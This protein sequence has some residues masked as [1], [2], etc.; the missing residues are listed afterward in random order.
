MHATAL[1]ELVEWW[2]DLSRQEINSRAVLL[3]VPPRWGRTHLLNQFTSVV[4]DDE[5]VS[6]VIRVPGASLPDGLG[7]QALELRRLFSEARVQ[8]RVAELLGVDRLGSA[9]Q[10]GLGVAGL[11][12]SPLATLVGL[13]LASV[14]VGA[15]SKVWDD[16][17]AGQEGMVAKLARAVATVSVSVP[18]VVIMDDADQLQP[19]LTVVLVENLIGRFDGRVLVV[20]AADPS[21]DLISALTSRAKYGLT[22]GRVRI[23]DAD[24]EMDYQA[25]ADLA[26]ELSPDLPA[27]AT[28]RIGQRTRTFAEV[29]AVTSAERL[30]ELDAQGDEAATVI[31]VDEVI[32][33]QVNRAPPSKLAVVLAWV[34]GSMH[35]RQAERAVKVLG[36]GWPGD[37]S[38][39]IRF[40]SLIRLADPASPRL[41]E[42]VRVLAASK[43]LSMAKIVLDTALEIGGH[44]GA[45]LVDKVVA[46]QA[47]HR[48]RADLADRAQLLGVQDRLV[49]GLEDLD[50]PAAAYQVAKTALAEYLANEPSPREAR[51][52]DDLSAA[53]LRL[54]R[55]QQAAKTDRLIDATINAVA[56]G[57]A[58]V[59]LEARIWAAIDLLGQPGQRERALGLTDRVAIE[60]SSRKDLGPIGNRWRLLLAFHT[61]RVGYPA[62][63]QQLLAPML[64]A[65]SMAE[66]GDAAR[67]VLYAV[68]GPRADTR[69]QIIGLEAEL[70]TLP[71]DA[72]SDHLRLHRALATDYTDLGDYRRAL[73]HREQELPLRR[74]IQGIDHPDTLRVR[75]SIAFCTGQIGHSAEALR[76]SRELL[77][78]LAR[79]LGPGHPRTLGTR[80]NIAHLI[81]QIGYPAEALRLFQELLPDQARVLGPDHPDIFR[82]RSNIASYTG[83]SG[84]PA[85]ALRL[86][87]ELL[88]DRA[89]VLG[90]D[91]PD[92][93]TTRSN[94]ASYTGQSG[95]PAEALRLFQELLPDRARVL[96]PDHPDT[97]ITRSNI[98]SYTGQSGHPAEA[99]RLSR[100]LLPDRA[101]VLGPDHPDTLTTCSNIASYT[102]Q[103]GHPAEALRLFQELL[104]DQ[105]RVLGPDHPDTLIT[106]NNI[107]SWAGES[108]YPAEALRLFQELLPDQAR[109][110]GP[111]HPDTLTTRSNIA[112]YTGQSG[113]PAEALRLSR[114]LLPDRARV[115]GPDH[116]DTL[117]TRN[118]I[119]SYTGQSGHPAEALRLFQELLP[120]QARVLGPDHP[121]TLITR[122]NIAHWAGE[123]G[124]PA[125]AL[126]LFQELLPDW[127]RVL[128][129]DHPDALS[130]RN[131][132]ASYT[133]QSGHP[134]EAL[135]LFR[136]LLPDRARVLGP[137]H[138]DTFR[139]RS[140]IASWAGRSGHP[141]E[142]LRL[143]RELLPDQARV[144][145]PHHPDTLVTRNNTAYLTAESGCSEE[146]LRLFRELLPDQE[147]VLGLDHPNTLNTR[148]NIEQLSAPD[149][150]PRT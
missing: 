137:D 107:A 35:V 45:G 106:R 71:P 150:S 25:R 84:H 27:T 83:Q 132:I 15:A 94:I 46:W 18:V 44:P 96:G 70:R 134:A 102:G 75:N 58:A 51:E 74:R 29:F 121:G 33:A 124:Y 16:S 114:E 69:L 6:I 116:P 66:D 23:V 86:S 49:H 98:A 54:A 11:F 144:L 101:R 93:L 4:E 127:T 37:N 14:G 133:G 118:N 50:D 113:H 111:D 5:A 53:L 140:N 105:A 78:D 22:E 26:A 60:L 97:L 135:R 34:G 109:V 125:E 2:Q 17:L 7:L 129:P 57:G 12:A 13:L 30:V 40:E 95:H 149:A 68:G 76:L 120:D 115:L 126:R 88:P 80:N 100:E 38:D 103:S 139:T 10:L 21:G 42:Q 8:H 59:G 3:P 87:R 104:P 1:D 89:R 9:T 122:S 82:T 119:A 92:T 145:G 52:H 143:F 112:S 123:S 43:R 63:T 72:D 28:G 146:A 130:A 64:D 41:Q 39:V 131:N 31:A 47:A 77:P 141:A 79:V 136:E 19:D 67:T 36:E 90:P 110:L 138:P 65:F 56:V 48:V 62:I 61:G 148:R 20:A 24:P 117:T 99:L 55:T 32:D 128:G 81:G 147:R 108:G 142:A 85:E 91:H 73:G